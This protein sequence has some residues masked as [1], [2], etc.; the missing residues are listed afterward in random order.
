MYWFNLQDLMLKCLKDS[1][2]NINIHRYITFTSARTRATTHN[3]LKLNY[4]RTSTTHYFYFNRV[5]KL[6]NK[7]PYN[8]LD[9]SLS[10]GTL[11]MRLHHYLWTNF[12]TSFDPDRVC[13]FQLSYLSML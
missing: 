9:L 6:W 13:I 2:D 12:I 5:V 7:I 10:L 4:I 8:I 11:K 1:N 3:Q